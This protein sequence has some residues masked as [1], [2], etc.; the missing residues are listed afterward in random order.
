LTA[1]LQA[2]ACVS[3]ADPAGCAP[4]HAAAAN[5]HIAAV[6]LLLS[7]GARAD[8]C[9]GAG[10][11]ALHAAARKG[12]G[13]VLRGLLR[14]A[15]ASAAGA[16]NAAGQ[17]PLHLA[18]AGGH[19]A[20][21]AILLSVAG[22]DSSRALDAQGLSPLHRAGAGGHA[23]VVRQLL[24]ASPLAVPEL[25]IALFLADVFGQMRSLAVLLH[26]LGRLDAAAA[27]MAL[28]QVT[29]QGPH[30]ALKLSMAMLQMWVHDTGR[31]MAK[32]A[33]LSAQQ[34][35]QIEVRLAMQQV[36]LGY[37]GLECQSA[38]A[39]SIVAQQE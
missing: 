39:A 38:T 27:A 20:C 13:V 12:H 10:D 11:T 6:Q 2:G 30:A 19:Q 34:Q 22:T 15:G 29:V 23:L 26:E 18:A 5:G 24:R 16:C 9:N 1:L 28:Q 14:R 25:Q 8:A 37:A 35:Q 7:A 21:V 17:R 31:D 4:L 3:R 33:A 32:E 36:V